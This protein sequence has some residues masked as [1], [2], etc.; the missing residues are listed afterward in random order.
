LEIPE[1]KVLKGHKVLLAQALLAILVLLATLVH[2]D[3]QEQQAILAM[4]KQA[5]PDR[6]A[7]RATPVLLAI[8]AILE[9]DLPVIQAILAAQAILDLQAIEV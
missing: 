7:T 8:L 2:K 3:L 5:L 6:Q 4:E 1:F 9:L